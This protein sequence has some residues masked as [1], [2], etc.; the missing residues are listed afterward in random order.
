MISELVFATHNH[1]KLIEI[2]SQLEGIYVLKSLTTLGLNKEIPENENTLAGNALA[3]ARY[4]KL[5]TG[6]DCFADDTGLEIDALHGEPGV[7]SARYAGEEKNSEANMQK[8]LHNLAT[9]TTRTARFKTVIALIINNEELLFE[10]E[11]EGEIMTEKRGNKGFGYDPI[12]KPAGFD[13]TF[14]EMSLDEKKQISHRARAVQKL[15]D[16]LQKK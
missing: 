9:S 14:A 1:N 13:R 5:H 6:L 3:K 12:F 10:G 15:V 11:V 4:V 7:F 8:V 16:Y 2:Q